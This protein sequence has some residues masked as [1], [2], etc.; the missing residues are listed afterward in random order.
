[1]AAAR[2]YDNIMEKKAYVPLVTAMASRVLPAV[3]NFA[4]GLGFMGRKGQFTSASQTLKGNRAFIAGRTGALG[5]IVAAPTIKK[6]NL[7]QITKGF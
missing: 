5:S 3:G 1:M 6:T 2:G 7:E 4:R